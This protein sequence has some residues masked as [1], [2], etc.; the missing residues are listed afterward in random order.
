M[1]AQHEAIVRY[2]FLWLAA[3]TLVA[4]AGIARAQEEPPPIGTDET[5][6]PSKDAELNDESIERVRNELR[7]RPASR[8][9]YPSSKSSTSAASPSGSVDVAV[10]AGLPSIDPLGPRPPLLAEGSF[11]VRRR[12]VLMVTD[13]GAY[14]FAFA[15]SP[16]GTRERP[17]A[18]IPC[19]VLRRMESAAGATGEGARSRAAR[20]QVVGAFLLS[21]QITAYAGR[22]YVLP[23]VFSLIDEKAVSP[24][25]VEPNRERPPAGVKDPEI[26]ELISDL[27]SLRAT[28]RTTT[29][30]RTQPGAQQNAALLADDT[31]IPRRKARLTRTPRGE[32]ALVFDSGPE[33]TGDVAMILVPCTATEGIERAAA[34]AG[35]GAMFDVSGRVF[36][37]QGRNYF[38]PVMYI[39]ETSRNVKPLR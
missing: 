35:D 6:D 14:I 4:P 16:E 24:D 21:G 30:T 39:A 3:V 11:I 1:H 15:P 19:E 17:M 31:V 38:L 29:P 2:V 22:N 36:Q 18:V 20:V 26:D 13:W 32:A 34:R 33:G 8:I 9:L 12:G 5:A 37:H 27:E 25:A 10:E 7:E 28:P 23:T